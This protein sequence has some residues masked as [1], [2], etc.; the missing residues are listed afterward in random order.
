MSKLIIKMISVALIASLSSI[1]YADY[2]ISIPLEK[3]NGGFLSDGSIVFVKN[4]I[5]NPSLP[6]SPELPVELTEEEKDALCTSYGPQILNHALS[7]GVSISLN[8]SRDNF[9]YHAGKKCNA[10]ITW[11]GAFE[12]ENQLASLGNFILGLPV[13]E[14]GIY[15]TNSVSPNGRWLIK[16]GVLDTSFFEDFK[17]P[18]L[19]ASTFTQTSAT[20]NYYN[21]SNSLKAYDS[22]VF[23]LNTSNLMAGVNYRLDTGVSSCVVKVK[24]CSM[25]STSAA[26]CGILDSNISTGTKRRVEPTTGESC[27]FPS[28][29][30]SIKI[31]NL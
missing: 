25:G 30:I 8:I 15:L 17:N 4:N 26:G 7:L 18:P 23:I 14:T 12:T 13:D 6:E 29:P 2:I 19:F 24:S 5:Q 27:S 3:S 11:A 9:G 31:K 21:G 10:Y 20:S 22:P 28:G 1:V 16:D